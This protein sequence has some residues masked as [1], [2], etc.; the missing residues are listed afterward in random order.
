MSLDLAEIVRV[1]AQIAPEGLVRRDFGRTLFVHT[2]EDSDDVLLL[3]RNTQIREYGN[4]TAVQKD[5]PRGPVY[6]AARVYFAQDP[7]PKNFMVAGYFPL[8]S[9]SSLRGAGIDNPAQIRTIAHSVEVAQGRLAGMCEY[10]SDQA[11]D[12]AV[13][14]LIHDSIQNETKLLKMVGGGNDGAIA[15]AGDLRARFQ[16]VSKYTSEQIQEPTGLFATGSATVA[17]KLWMVGKDANDNYVAVEVSPADGAIGVTKQINGLSAGH[18]LAGAAWWKLAVDSAN[19]L[20]F[21][22]HAQDVSRVY[23]GTFDP[24]NAD[25][26]ALAGE[27]LPAGITNVQ[28]LSL[29]AHGD[30]VQFADQGS[31]KIYAADTSKAL[32]AADFTAEVGPIGDTIGAVAALFAIPG[33]DTSIGILDGTNS[34][35]SSYLV[36]NP[37]T[38]TPVEEGAQIYSDDVVHN[39]TIGEL[40]PISVSFI[41]LD[42][43][44]P[45]EEQLAYIAGQISD[46]LTALPAL[47]QTSVTLVNTNQLAIFFPPSVDI[48]LGIAINDLT[49]AL[50]I[51]RGSA[52]IVA[53][54][55]AETITEALGRISG[56]N[57][58]WYWLTLS[59]DLLGQSLAVAQWVAGTSFFF[60]MDNHEP[61]ALTPN[62]NTSV[63]SQ[64]SALESQRVFAVWSLFPDYKAVSLAARFSSVD[65][66]AGQSLITGKFKTLPGTTPDVITP[67]QK[68]ELDRKRVNHYSPFG[69]DSIVAEGVSFGTFI[70]V[71]FWLDW[72]INSCQIG[73]YNLLKGS[74][75]RVPQTESGS[76]AIRGELEGICEEG[77]LNGGIAP[78]QLGTV[79]AGNVREITGNS[80]FTGYLSTGYLVYILPIALQNPTDR[81]ARKAPPINIWVKGSGAVHFLDINIV[82]EN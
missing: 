45:V 81:A 30:D 51:S 1:N 53:G 79:L 25:A 15:G 65:F 60:A 77:V 62:E 21:S 52:T 75:S 72:F 37:N 22:N 42:T 44:D 9:K 55:N 16:L 28:G 41:G 59:N 19:F 3:E 2:P 12:E 36:A 20:A 58:E 13:Y 66:A 35:L 50:G 46:A 48:S 40:D 23:A 32:D 61:G 54:I 29:I 10:Y 33:I 38:V 18:T 69:G 57:G 34:R 5:W 67:T 6:D 76:A 63:L 8:G 64:V 49:F 31:R 78:G 56:A 74:P 43:D 39:I 7:F 11:A 82:F 68:A 27:D 80:K 71:R 73:V 70:D 24:G 17:N 47:A 4:L 26:V 14:L